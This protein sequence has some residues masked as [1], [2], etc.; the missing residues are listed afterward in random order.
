[1]TT[2]L[3]A[4]RHG[5]GLF[6]DDLKLKLQTHPENMEEALRRVHDLLQQHSHDEEAYNEV[7]PNMDVQD[8]LPYQLLSKDDITF[9]DYH[10]DYHRQLKM[11][12]NPHSLKHFACPPLSSAYR[13]VH[14]M[15]DSTVTLIDHYS[16][17]GRWKHNDCFRC[18]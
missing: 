7:A 3:R 6:D 8:E 4:A 13:R 9:R 10:L 11:L 17:G 1:M 5:C 15:T 12:L 14:F 2:P 18:A 16:G